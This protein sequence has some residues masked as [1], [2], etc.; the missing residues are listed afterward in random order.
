M[1]SRPAASRRIA[2]CSDRVQHNRADKAH[3]WPGDCTTAPGS[4]QKAG[5]APQPH[6]RFKA[7]RDFG[8]DGEETGRICFNPLERDG[9]GK[10]GYCLPTEG[11]VPSPR[12]P[13]VLPRFFRRNQFSWTQL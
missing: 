11:G 4:S 3:T 13:V 12:T 10:Y 1:Q 2:P 9:P 7:R 5:D 8:L 6:V